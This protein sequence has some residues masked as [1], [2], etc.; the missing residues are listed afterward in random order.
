MFQFQ[1]G[2]TDY[3]HIHFIGIGGISMSGLAALM[4]SKGYTISG[5]DRK[6]SPITEHLQE[7]GITVYEDHDPTQIEDADLVVYTD[8]IQMDN[9]EYRAAIAKKST[10]WTG[11]RSSAPS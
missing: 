4:L 5:S 9:P 11:L 7:L 10:L 2:T 6:A 1:F 8:A 3:H